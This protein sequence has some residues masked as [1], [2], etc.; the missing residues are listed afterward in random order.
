[1]DFLRS[2]LGAVLAIWV[3]VIL[4]GSCNASSHQTM[5]QNSATRPTIV[6]MTDFGTANDAGGDL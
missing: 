6:F 2:R 5:A 4:M 3:L 1:M